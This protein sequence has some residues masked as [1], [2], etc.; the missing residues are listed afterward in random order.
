M[1][2]PEFDVDGLL[3]P[4]THAC[5]FAELLDVFGFTNRRK[6]LIQ[7][8]QKVVTE[9]RKTWGHPIY[10]DGSFVTRVPKPGDLDLVLDLRACTEEERSAAFYFWLK[11]RGQWSAKWSIHFQIDLP[12]NEECFI[13]SFKKV[14]PKTALRLGVG[15]E[16]PKGILVLS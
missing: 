8:A 14:G 13:E 1:P 16:R 10:L 2:V 6:Q 5:D 12:S 15:P 9:V 3:P 4:G 11:Q 7:N